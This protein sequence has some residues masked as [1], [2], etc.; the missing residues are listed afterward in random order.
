MWV[1]AQLI[2]SSPL[3][4]SLE[5]TAGV[6][7]QHDIGAESNGSVHKVLMSAIPRID[8]KCTQHAAV[9]KPGVPVIA[10]EMCRET[11]GV[12]PCDARYGARRSP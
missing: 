5:T 6:F 12:H 4:R 3:T 2:V 1:Q 8:G 7:G 11:L 10:H 9:G